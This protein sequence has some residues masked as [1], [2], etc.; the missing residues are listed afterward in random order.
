MVCIIIA[1]VVSIGLT[2]GL[3]LL[4]YQPQ[5]DDFE[6]EIGTLES[7]IIDVNLELDSLKN[8]KTNLI[9]QIEEKTNLYNDL[10]KEYEIL[11]T[12]SQDIESKLNKLSVSAERL[13]VDRLFL[14]KRFNQHDS[15]TNSFEDEATLWLDIRSSAIDVDPD[16]IPLIDILIDDYRDLYIWIDKLPEGPIPASEAGVIMYEGYQILWKILH[17]DLRDFDSHWID[18]LKTDLAEIQ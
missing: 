6:E 16:L 14:E 11:N 4:V 3:V 7:R 8:D 15:I 10:M 2:L 13:N 18:I 9:S 1:I 17:K 12:F 5:L